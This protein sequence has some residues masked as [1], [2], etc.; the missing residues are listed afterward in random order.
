MKQYLTYLAAATVFAA[1]ADTIPVTVADFA[2]PYPIPAPY[3]VDSV[4]VNNKPFS[5]ASMLE[6]PVGRATMK[7]GRRLEISTLPSSDAPALGIISF[8]ISNTSYI[9]PGITVNGL[10]KNTIFVDGKKSDGKCAFTPGTHRVDIKY[11]LPEHASDSATVSIVTDNPSALQIGDGKR[12]YTLTDVLHGRRISGVSV[13]P[14]LP[15]GKTTWEWVV[16]TID[17]QAIARSNESIAW[18]PSG[19]RYF[20]TAARPDGRAIEVTDATTGTTSLFAENIPDG[21]FT[22]SPDEELSSSQRKSPV[23]KKTRV[24]T[25]LSSRKTDSPAGATAHRSTSTTLPQA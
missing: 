21:V 16:S 25:V 2:G 22:I 20:R 5:L 7:Q 13:S 9:E 4:D 17:G 10:G 23:R 15:G 24:C 18:M 11:L 1:S 8:N 6:A 3:S 12:L 14:G 19:S